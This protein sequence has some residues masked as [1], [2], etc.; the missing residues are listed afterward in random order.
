M[1]TSLDLSSN[2]AYQELHKGVHIFKDVNDAQVRLK[3]GKCCVLGGVSRNKYL[4]SYDWST[5]LHLFT[6]FRLMKK[7][8]ILN[9]YS[10]FPLQKFSPYTDLFSEHALRYLL[11]SIVYNSNKKFII[12]LDIRSM[13]FQS[14]GIA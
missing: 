13:D 5:K 11:L 14:I 3:S 10:V 6:S 12:S 8:C 7:V 1:A 2:P 4:I 9:Y